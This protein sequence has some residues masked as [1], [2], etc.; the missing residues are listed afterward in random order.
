MKAKLKNLQFKYLIN[1]LHPEY[2][3]NSQNSIMIKLL[4][5]SPKKIFKRHIVKKNIQIANKNMKM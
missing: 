5:T 2:I 4:L 1:N 3:K